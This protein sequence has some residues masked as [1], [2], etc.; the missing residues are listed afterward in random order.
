MGA[1]R[2]RVVDGQIDAALATFGAVLVTG[3]KWC[4]KTTTARRHASSELLVADPAGD[5]SARSLA[6]LDPALALEG[7]SPRLV[8][9][10]QEVPKLFDAARFICDE[11]GGSGHF[12]FTGSATPRD[13]AAPMHSGTG[14][15]AR[16][17]MQTMT[18]FESGAAA[19]GVSLAAL[20]DGEEPS[21]QA[22]GLSVTDIAELVTRGGW[23]GSLDMGLTSAAAVPMQYIQT[24]AETD[25][26]SLEGSRRD[27]TRT[28]ALI[29]SLGRNESTL[30][31]D[32]TIAADLAG[33]LSRPTVLSRLSSLRR[34]NV[35]RDVPA[36]HPA[37]RSPIRLRQAVKRHLADP[38][39]AVAALGADPSALLGDVKTL[40]LLFESLALRD[41][42]VFAEA[43]G[44]SLGHYSD[45][46][47]READAVVS[48]ADGR[49]GLF[50][51]KLGHGQVD[52]AAGALCEIER[53]MV[54]AGE[55]P[56][57]VKCVLIGF[58]LPA[59]LRPDGVCVVPIDVL[60]P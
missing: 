25:M 50:E 39:L 30:A 41:L 18:L 17:A 47:G 58:G 55:R 34:L 42:G 49:W 7:D 22:G 52:A 57:S 23:P 36:W 44:G 40:G 48:L 3:P 32:R 56:P 53:V 8:D 60:E 31:S 54:A 19:G 4:G 1:Y 6:E 9:E 2:P 5:F 15:F 35:V 33:S 16:V 29:A 46:V 21:G 11:R 14:R 43:M 20:M 13:D 51:V 24:V 26:P 28:L 10:W 12:L 59:H 45:Y 38:S 37:L 27:P